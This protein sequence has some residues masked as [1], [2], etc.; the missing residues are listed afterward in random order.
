M[1]QQNIIQSIRAQFTENPKTGILQRILFWHDVEQSFKEELPAIR[2]A[3]LKEGI[4]ILDMDG[5]KL[6]HLMT[7][8]RIEIDEPEQKFLLYFTSEIPPH[9][10]DWFLDMR[11]Y[12][13]TFHADRAA[14]TMAELGI[15]RMVLR[16]HISKRSQFLANKRRVEQ[17]KRFITEND[18]ERSLDLKMIAVLLKTKTA[19]LEELLFQL[20]HYYIKAD[21]AEEF[22]ALE[23]LKKYNLFTTF[24]QA[25][26]EQYGYFVDP[27]NKEPSLEEVD[28][29]FIEKAG[30]LNLLF[31]LFSTE[32]DE[33]IKSSPTKKSW[34]QANVIEQPSGRATVLAFM[35]NWRDS[36][37]FGEDYQKIAAYI[38][39]RLNIREELKR[40][41]AGELVELM[42]FEDVEQLT[43]LNLMEKLLHFET[44]D[45]SFV[46]QT[47]NLRNVGY[48]VTMK[49]N[50]QEL[51][52]A[53]TVAIA[54][55]N[56][57]ETYKDGFKFQYAHE[58]FNAYSKTLY[59]FD[60]YY[61]EYMYHA[62]QHS[63]GGSSLLKPLTNEIE[64]RYINRYSS[65]LNREW[66]RLMEKEDLLQRWALPNIPKQEHFFKGRVE[67]ECQEA[68]LNRIYVIISDALR[69]EVAQSLTEALNNEALFSAEIAPQLGVIP[70]Y[71]QL[72]MAA[73]LP[74]KTLA[75][76]G[77]KNGS[78][79]LFAD[80]ASTQGL[81]NRR[82]ILSRVNGVAFHAKEL[83]NFTREEEKEQRQDAKYIYIYHDEID[84]T[85]DNAATESKTFTACQTAVE[86]I[87]GLTRKIISTFKGSRVLIT[88]DHG[89]VF[90]QL[91]VDQLDR[92]ELTLPPSTG[93][94]GGEIAPLI[95]KKRYVVHPK[96]VE[97]EN[98]WSAPIKQVVS[99]F[100]GEEHFIIPKGWQRFHFTGGAQFI[101]GG[102]S[103]QEICV[104]IITVKNRGVK[105]RESHEARRLVKVISVDPAPRIVNNITKIHLLQTEQVSD[106]VLARTINV[107]IVDEEGREVSNRV[108]L[109]FGSAEDNELPRDQYAQLSLI[110]ND[111]H[112]DHKY[113]LI[114]ED[115]ESHVEIETYPAEINLAFGNEF[116]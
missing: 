21:Y 33:Y 48:W 78:G 82:E 57:S 104:P 27:K 22:T 60:Q 3:L 10:E 7:K 89:F 40:Y 87:L 41:E 11:L 39:G 83:Q 67:A 94:K 84:A 20:F 98:S 61:R 113:R 4:I 97:L 24:W 107:Y 80:G 1:S 25:I 95:K 85:G 51:Y 23:E 65:A 53:L 5:E 19:T 31:K 43:L 63:A 90:Q 114:L 75:Y 8:K 102:A 96:A 115:H 69:Y 74:H 34:F 111:F 6:S 109:R 101:H 13:P 18:D 49:P 52:K 30:L 14:L 2:E 26:V 17:L 35:A 45:Q 106:S 54:F 55:M 91:A 73:L 16:P 99:T 77:A 76:E 66:E 38:G 116:F 46:E 79:A 81:A 56:L 86:Q 68:N 47:I 103:L 108:T 100:V 32:L 37:K 15:N 12:S 92:T 71:T 112:R 58:M 42:T 110:G 36:R 105:E 9:K 28:A 88:A 70:S 29:Q 72:G 93:A 62:L 59:K 44:L 64:R 50:Y